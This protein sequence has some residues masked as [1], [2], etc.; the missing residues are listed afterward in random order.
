[1]AAPTAITLRDISTEGLKK[2][3]YADPVSTQ[4]SLITRAEDSWMREMKNDIF[5][6][7]KKLTSLQTRSIVTLVAGRARYDLPTDFSSIISMTLLDGSHTGTA[8]TGAAGSITLASAETETS[9]VNGKEI[10]ITGGTGVNQISQ[11]YTYNATTKI[12]SVYPNW[13]T[14]PDSTSTYLIV[15][16]YNEL[17]EHPVWEYDRESY[18]YRKEKPVA[19][20][21]IG[22]SDDGEFLLVQ[23]PD[24]AYAVQIRY[25]ADL[26]RLDL[27]GTLMS[28]LY[29]RWQNI[30]V[31]GIWAK[32]LEHQDD[33]NAATIKD[34]YNKKIQEL[35]MR[36]GYGL[37]LSNLQIRVQEPE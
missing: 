4:S 22:D 2:A 11:I 8:Q 36:E 17:K 24:E 9:D 7:S 14:T 13:T 18:K 12:A 16:Q 10:V 19:Y 5:T 6:A 28:T 23:A 1:M 35:T 21:P 37:D 3:G 29:R 27:T 30:W 31:T 15:D 33:E 25:Y 34:A 20:Y 26:T 32:A